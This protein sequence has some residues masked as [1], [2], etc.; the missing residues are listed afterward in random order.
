MRS[1]IAL[2]LAASRS[3]ENTSP[4]FTCTSLS[5]SSRGR[6][7]CPL[8]STLETTYFYTVAAS[9]AAGKSG[10]SGEVSAKAYSFDQLHMRHNA[11][12]LR[13]VASGNGALVAVGDGMRILRSTD[14]GANWADVFV[15]GYDWLETVTY[16]GGKFVAVGSGGRIIVS[17][18]GLTW[19]DAPSGVTTSFFTSPL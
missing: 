15:S 13:G 19:E 3:R 2:V 4:G 11:Q 7:S 1:E 5:S 16:G 18:D 6:S 10:P 17:S 14:G 9:N 8:S 12:V